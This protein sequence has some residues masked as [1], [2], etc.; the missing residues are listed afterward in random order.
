[1]DRRGSRSSPDSRP[2][3][4][5]APPLT[6][7]V[8]HVL[9]ALADGPLHGYAVMRS[10]E[11]TAGP[12]LRMGPGTV[13]GSLQRME[14]AGLVAEAEGGGERR[15]TFALTAAGR[16]A[17]AA[18]AARLVRLADLVRARHLAPGEA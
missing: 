6:P 8:F 10:V 9:L 17:L 14:E 1:M 2:P 16:Q 7:A 5:G 15:R 4:L 18:E 12:E 13:Y 11:R 3:S